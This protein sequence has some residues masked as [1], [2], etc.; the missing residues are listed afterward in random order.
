M[1]SSLGQHRN[2][3]LQTNA[4]AYSVINKINKKGRD[5]RAAIKSSSRK[6]RFTVI[7]K[8]RSVRQ[9]YSELGK[10]VFRR[11]YRMNLDTFF[12]LYQE[13]KTI[14]F[15][16][17]AYNPDRDFAPNGRVH[18]TVRLACFLR[19]FAGGEAPDICSTFGVSKTVVHDSVDFIAQ[20]VNETRHFDITFPTD[21]SEQQKI[22]DGFKELSDID[23]DICCAAEDGMLVWAL[24]PSKGECK[25]ACVGSKKFFCGRKKKFGVNMQGCCDR[26][27]RFLNISIKFPAA[28]S[29]FL[30]FE[31]TSFRKL[32]ETPGFLAPGL[33]LFGDNAYVNRFYMATPYTNVRV[34]DSRDSYNFF[35]SQLRSMIECAFGILVQRWG[36]LRKPMSHKFSI[37]KICVV[38]EVACKL[39]NFLIDRKEE[40]TH[41]PSHTAE[42]QLNMELNGAIPMQQTHGAGMHEN[43]ALPEQLLHGGEH[44]DDDPNAEIRNRGY[45]RQRDNGCLLPRELL[46]NMV[47]EGDYRRPRPRGY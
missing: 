36:I 25:K 39:H 31:A 20:A 46:A 45:A 19:I 17:L 44:F 43:T 33:C 22:A 15:R 14:L 42:D 26:L 23:I 29:D 37:K 21:H 9:V 13:I 40:A 35:H 27:Y 32:L 24:K 38:V 4:V 2:R 12:N 28:T 6:G 30:A 7:R 18:P 34:T 8:R 10:G 47:K 1:V 11:A 5:T 41:A 16:V 3:L